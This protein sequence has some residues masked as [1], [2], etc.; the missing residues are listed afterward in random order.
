MAASYGRG[1]VTADSYGV[2]FLLF[3]F[4]TERLCF[5]LRGSARLPSRRWPGRAL[6]W[7]G[8]FP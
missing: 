2:S 5:L 3:F 6:V 1:E 8:G 7:M 4:L